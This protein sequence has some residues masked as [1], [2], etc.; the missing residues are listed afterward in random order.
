MVEYKK[1]KS[2]YC[3]KIYKNKKI[4][5]SNEEYKKNSQKGG[6]HSIH[7]SNLPRNL[8]KGC[9]ARCNKPT[10]KESIGCYS[11]CINR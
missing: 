8:I 4:R 3:Y 2:G 5:I 6:M 7:P 10:V 9:R 1:Y 11:M